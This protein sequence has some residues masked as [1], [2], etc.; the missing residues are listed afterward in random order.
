M[1]AEPIDPEEIH[2]LVEARLDLLG[3]PEVVNEA[4]RISGRET[5]DWAARKRAKAL[6]Q[7]GAVQADAQ[8]QRDE[9]MEAIAP[10]LFPIDLYEKD[11]T[12]RLYREIG[13]W[14]AKL[15][16]WHRAELA[17]DDKLKTIKLPHATL[18]S[19]K[20]PDHWEFGDGFLSW[21]KDRL[22]T[23]VRVKEEIDKAAVKAA[24]KDWQRM[25]D[26]VFVSPEGEVIPVAV[27]P[28][29]VNFTIE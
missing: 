10:Y 29:E 24:L 17:E 25:D 13:H 18:R 28:G 3:A 22:P 16:Q 2:E 15:A 8:R 4:W 7:L 19:R 9:I 23:V 14:E 26:G 27:Q 1:T 5:A 12:E 11:E 21:A 20:N 6:G